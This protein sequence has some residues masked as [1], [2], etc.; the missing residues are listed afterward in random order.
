NAAAAAGDNAG[1]DLLCAKGA[2]V[3]QAAGEVLFQAAANNRFETIDHL[4]G[5]GFKIEAYGRLV[6]ARLREKAPQSAAI[7][8]V[9]Q[10]YADA[11]RESARKRL[12]DRRFSLPAPDTLAETV[13]LP[14]G[15]TLTMLFN[16]TL[17]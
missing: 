9:E 14:A 6:A 12:A 15:G 4:I 8:F 3:N 11:A 16:F 5:K 13:V 10:R 1:I 7:A 2:D 17:R